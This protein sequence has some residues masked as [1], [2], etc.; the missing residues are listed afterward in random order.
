MLGVRGRMMAIAGLILDFKKEKSK[1]R[2][3]HTDIHNRRG[4]GGL[5]GGLFTCTRVAGE[6]G[7]TNWERGSVGTYQHMVAGNAA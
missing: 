3:K 1:G 7:A 2:A 6:R 4:T 5:P